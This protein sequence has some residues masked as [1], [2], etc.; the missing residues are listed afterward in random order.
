MTLILLDFGNTAAVASF[1]EITSGSAG[2][3][4]RNN[5]S[6]MIGRSNGENVDEENG[7]KGAE[8]FLLGME[9]E[10]RRR[11]RVVGFK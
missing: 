1:K 6:E 2:F 8:R 7:D 9:Q 3:Q 5:N 10:S 11:L 4:Y